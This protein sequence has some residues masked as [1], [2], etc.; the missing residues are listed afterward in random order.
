VCDDG[1]DSNDATVVCRQV[2]CGGPVSAH[3]SAHFGAGSGPIHLDNVGCSGSEK[4]ITD[5]NHNGFGTLVH[6]GGRCSGRV[7]I[8]YNGQWGTVCDDDWGMEDAEVVCSQM[9]CGKATSIHNKAHFGQGSGPILLDDVGCSGTE[10]P[11]TSCSHSGFGNHN[12]GHGE[13]AGVVCSGKLVH[14]GGRCSGRVEIYYNGQWGTVCDDDWGME[15]AEVVCSQMA[16]GKATSIHNQAHFGQGS[17]PI[18]LDNVGCSGTEITLTSCSHSGLGI[19]NC[20]HGEDAGVVCSDIRLVNGTDRCSGRVEIYHNGQW[21]TVCDDY[22][23]MEDAEV[24]CSQ[25]GCGKATSIHDKAHF[26]QGSGPIFL[27]NVGCSGTETTLTSCS[28]RGLGINDCSHGEDAGVVC[29]GKK[30]VLKGT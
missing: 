11:L 23:G 28:H 4:S 18:L 12:C 6:G 21:G 9:G 2:G 1:W 7:E 14:G 20:N 17:G 5:C 24:A 10:T 30:A 29:S 22:W 25:M 27:D 3:S 13:D 15:D 8:Y 19:N 26:G 16:C